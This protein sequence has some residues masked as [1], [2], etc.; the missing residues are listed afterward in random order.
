MRE[1]FLFV[2]ADPDFAAALFTTL[3]AAGK[4]VIR[5]HSMD[6]ALAT[7]HR[8]GIDSI[9]VDPALA[10]DPAL[11]ILKGAAAAANSDFWILDAARTRQL[12]ADLSG[13]P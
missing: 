10:D 12:V 1:T 7:L 5:A 9:L 2:G 6:D 11:P 4:F 3:E 8:L 13:T